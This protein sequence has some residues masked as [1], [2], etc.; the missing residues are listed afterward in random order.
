LAG[1]KKRRFR[2][3]GERYKGKRSLYP[4]FTALAAAVGLNCIVN[5]RITQN[6]RGWKGPLWVI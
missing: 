5:H 6:G 3:G 2:S 1:V 4:C